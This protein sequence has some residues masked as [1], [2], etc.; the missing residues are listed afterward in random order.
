MTL[1]DNYDILISLVLPDVYADWNIESSSSSISKWINEMS[2]VANF[3]LTSQIIYH[4]GDNNV[5]SA[6]DSNKL[7]T[8]TNSDLSNVINS[9]E[10]HLQ[11]N[12]NPNSK[13]VQL[14]AY[15][16]QSISAPLYFKE[17]QK[18]KLINNIKY[19]FIYIFLLSGALLPDWGSFAILDVDYDELSNK[20]LVVD[21]V[22]AGFV[23]DMTILFGGNLDDIVKERTTQNIQAATN[24][25][26]SLSKL[27]Q[28]VRVS[29]VLALV[30]CKDFLYPEYGDQ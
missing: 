16:P 1:S 11:S 30:F 12:Q 17:Q 10:S 3:T 8:W 28:R 13:M 26:N 6:R 22:M 18:R 14:V 21:S 29:H 15:V 27:L 23:S 25:L 5:Q 2:P 19:K 20:M 7:I 9:I 4:P 24:S